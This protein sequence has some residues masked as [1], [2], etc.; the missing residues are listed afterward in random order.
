MNG[1]ALAVP[2]RFDLEPMVLRQTL[3]SLDGVVLPGG[4]LSIRRM[5]DMPPKTQVYYRTATAIIKYVMMYNL[6]LLG[7]C[8]GYQLLCQIT[9]DLLE[10]VIAS[11]TDEQA[12]SQEKVRTKLEIRDELLSD[13]KIFGTARTT[14]W[15]HQDVSSLPFF[16]KIPKEQ[17]N[18]YAETPLNQHYHNWVVTTKSFNACK[19]LPD[20]FHIVGVDDG[21]PQGM[22][23]E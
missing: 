2:I 8:Q 18:H 23:Q 5:A 3:D 17:L 11:E 16:Q 12:A 13:L 9:I 21:L 22:S 1:Q 10:D 7:I 20:F 15:K 4:F 19:A 6:P 14:I